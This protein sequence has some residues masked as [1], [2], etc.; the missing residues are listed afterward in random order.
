[1]LRHIPH[2]EQVASH[3]SHRASPFSTNAN[4]PVKGHEALHSVPFRKGEVL[5]GLQPRHLSAPGPLHVAHDGEQ[6][7]QTP[8]DVLSSPQVP[9]GVQSATHAPTASSQ[10]LRYGELGAQEVQSAS[11]EPVHVAHEAWHG[12]HL[13][14]CGP[15]PP[16]HVKPDS[17]VHVSLQPSKA[18]LL[19][20]SQASTAARTPSPQTVVHVSLL[21]ISP[22]SQVHPVST[23]QVS[24]HPSSAIVL[25]SSQAST[26]TRR[27]SPQMGEHAEVPPSPLPCGLLEEH[28]YPSSILHRASQPSSPAV[29]PSSQASAL[30]IR[31]SP[32]TWTTL[33]VPNSSTVDSFAMSV[34]TARISASG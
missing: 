11:P 26:P 3:S 23:I 33:A 6:G 21:L 14:D 18:T 17:I 13:S 4:V 19:P 31:A 22:P 32:Q 12:T 34:S 15:P 9:S 8:G 10:P 27:P 1:M 16:L 5:T 24:L 7:E 28:T 2:S 29:L 30:L 20:S 25:P